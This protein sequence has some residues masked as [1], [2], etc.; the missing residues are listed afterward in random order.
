MQSASGS[1]LVLIGIA[2]VLAETGTLDLASI[3]ASAQATPALLAAGALFIIGFGVKVALVPLHTWLP[4]AH[5]QAPQRY[6]RHAFGS[7]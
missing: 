1:V 6:Q 5:A 3:G 4:D 2:L 7:W